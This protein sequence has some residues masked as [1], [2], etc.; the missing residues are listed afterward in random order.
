MNELMLEFKG[1]SNVL[2]MNRKRMYIRTC[3]KYLLFPGIPRKIN[4][5]L[6]LWVPDNHVG[7]LMKSDCV[8]INI[9][10]DT[11]AIYDVDNNPIQYIEV[12]NRGLFPVIL[13]SNKIIAELLIVPN[14]ECHMVN[15]KG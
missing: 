9:H 11:M 7:L 15:I 2:L 14:A 5:D 10:M 6:S 3:K 13:N 4:I 12:V 8:S 1:N